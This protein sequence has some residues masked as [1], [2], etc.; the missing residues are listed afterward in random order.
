MYTTVNLHGGNYL[1][2]FSYWK[3]NSNPNPTYLDVQFDG[4]SI[5]GSPFVSDQAP[6]PPESIS[7]WYTVSVPITVPT[8]LLNNASA[9]TLRFTSLNST[10]CC[11]GPT[12]DDVRIT[13]APK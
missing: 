9:H 11:D 3:H 5:P 4:V 8:T 1:L 2:T 10:N 6:V 12:I 7:E 13:T